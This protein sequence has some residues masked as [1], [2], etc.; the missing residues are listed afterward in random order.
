MKVGDLVTWKYP[1]PRYAHMI[2]VVLQIHRD[3]KDRGNI[4]WSCDRGREDWIPLGVL[5]VMNEN[6]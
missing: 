5:E 4:M 2:G 6:R 3:D 1:R